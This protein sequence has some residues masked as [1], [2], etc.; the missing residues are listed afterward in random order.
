MN[1][2]IL[3]GGGF[4]G[5]T[6]YLNYREHYDK[7]FIVDWYKPPTHKDSY[8]K[9]TL[10]DSL[11]DCDEVIESDV[12][13]ISNYR[14][15]FNDVSVVIMLNADTG[16]GSS[17]FSPYDSTLFNAS[18]CTFIIQH[19]I[20]EVDDLS[21]IQ[22]VFSSSRAVYGEGNWYCPSHGKQT[23]NRD[24]YLNKQHGLRSEVS[25]E[26][27]ELRSFDEDQPLEPLSI[28][29]LNKAFTEHA[30]QLLFK[31][32]P[33]KVIILR[34]Q[35]VYGKGQSRHNPYTGVLNWFSER[36]IKNEP[37]EIYENG[38]I[39]RDF[40]HVKDAALAIHKSIFDIQG[41]DNWIFNVGSGFPIRLIKVAE[42]LKELFSSTSEIRVSDKFRSGDVLGAYSDNARIKN[43]T[44]F[45]PQVSIKDGLED[46]VTWYKNI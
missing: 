41:T 34:F 13:D 39:E 28:Y 37:I 2:L 25:G 6:Y 46:Y 21:K 9:S 23:L 29:G 8:L 3:G 43:I 20:A 45:E 11:R 33:T 17:Y 12:Y 31:D 27:L 5:V 10:F 16:T 30:L 14:H 7:I 1:A 38:L 22:L 24:L 26:L 32:R 19:M 36:L 35:N 40:I 42:I 44:G 15:V 4:I 18:A